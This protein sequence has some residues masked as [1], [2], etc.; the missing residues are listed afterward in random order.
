VGKEERSQYLKE[1]TA[2][3]YNQLLMTTMEWVRVD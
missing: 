3:D 2:G 1:A